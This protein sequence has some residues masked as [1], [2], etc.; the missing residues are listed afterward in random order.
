MELE[1]HLFSKSLQ[2]PPV[3]VSGLIEPLKREKCEQLSESE[4]LWAAGGGG[5]VCES[6]VGAFVVIELK[7]C[8]TRPNSCGLDTCRNSD[9][10]LCQ[11][12]SSAGQRCDYVFKTLRLYKKNS[13]Y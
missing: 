2:I 1:E 10:R 11:P 3:H 5:G 6:G 9:A 7:S 8:H 4:G 12:A 13:F